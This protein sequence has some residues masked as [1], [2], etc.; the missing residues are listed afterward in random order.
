MT[1][2]P[3]LNTRLFR[4]SCSLDASHREYPGFCSVDVDQNHH[5]QET[6][7]HRSIPEHYVSRTSSGTYAIYGSHSNLNR[8]KLYV[9][10]PDDQQ[11]QIEHVRNALRANNYEE[12]PPI[13]PIS[14]PDKVEK[15]DNSR[16]LMLGLPYAQSTS[17]ILARIFES[18]GVNMYHKPTYTMSS[19]LVHPKNKTP[20]ERQ[21]GT[22][23]HITCND[24]PKHTYL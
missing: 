8:A 9:T 4:P 2:W 1:T 5:L 10:T 19:M 7:P 17:E 12:W 3:A 18:H 23:Y 21:C 24:D 22:I 16:R 14:K 6:H 13:V 11:A 15:N 20:K